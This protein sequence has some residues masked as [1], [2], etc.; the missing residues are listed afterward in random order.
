MRGSAGTSTSAPG[1]GVAGT[2]RTVTDLSAITR[3]TGVA[4]VSDHSFGTGVYG[5]SNANNTQTTGVWGQSTY[6]VAVYGAS[7][8]GYAAFWDGAVGQNGPA[9]MPSAAVRVDHPEDPEERYLEL[10]LA[11]AA[12]RTVVLDGMITLDAAGTAEV[13][14]PAWFA[15]VTER[16]RYQ[17]TAVGA[18]APALHVAR[19]LDGDTFTVA[20]GVP[21]QKISWQITGARRDPWAAAHPF[22]AEPLKPAAE[23]GTL[24]HP[25]LYGRPAEAALTAPR[26]GLAHNPANSPRER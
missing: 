2:S 9:T 1:I 21:G 10:P 17:L 15:R 3:Q 18:P 20:G 7:A 24:L 5:Q 22:S 13:R 6:G 14:L 25:E 23:R 11:A 12:E 4:G 16:H 19:E 8:N 26:R